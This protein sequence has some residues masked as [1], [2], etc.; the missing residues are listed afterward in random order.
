[1]KALI[2]GS[3]GFVGRYLLDELIT[4]GYTTFGIDIISDEHATIVNLLD[5]TAVKNYIKTVQPDVV[6]HLAA[7]AAIPYSWKEPQET[8]EFNIIGA[9]N[10]LE[11]VRDEKPTCK[12]LIVGSADQYGA[13]GSIEFISEDVPLTPRNPY[14]VSKKAQEEFTL[15]YSKANDLGVYLTRSFNHCGPGQK[16]GFLIPDICHGI[17][18]VERGVSPYLKIGNMEAVR[19]FTDVRDI[20]KAY[21]LIYEKGIS[22]EIYNVGSGHGRKAQE[23]LDRL[24]YMAVEVIPVTPDKERMRVSDTPVVICDNSKLQKHTGWV[25]IIPLEQT[26]KETLEYFRELDN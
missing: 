14:A 10:L 5:R 22:G 24:L 3:R 26:L 17:V 23:I 4:N 9:I 18:Q 19:D 6:F 2:T 21:R 1:M 12:V 13:T 20:V 8:F 16:L 11:A 15:V 25:P 7:Q